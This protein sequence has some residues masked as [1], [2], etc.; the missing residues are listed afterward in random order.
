MFFKGKSKKLVLIA[1]ANKLIKQSFSIAKSGLVYDEI[2]WN[3][4][5]FIVNY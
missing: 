4:P 2:V 5:Q 1:V 3:L